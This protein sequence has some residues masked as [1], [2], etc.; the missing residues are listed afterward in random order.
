MPRK[1]SFIIPLLLLICSCSKNSGGS[2]NVDSSSSIAQEGATVKSIYESGYDGGY[3]MKK[4]EETGFMRPVSKKEGTPFSDKISSVKGQNQQFMKSFDKGEYD[5]R[6]WSG[7]EK[8][9]SI[10]P[11]RNNQKEFQYSPHFIKE[12]SDLATRTPKEKM[13]SFSRPKYSTDYAREQSSTRIE[14]KPNYLVNKRQDEFQ[15]PSIISNQNYQENQSGRSV[16][17]VKGLLSN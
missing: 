12:N 13:S 9:K 4:D 6:R 10:L 17:D 5:A 7:A 2:S 15:Q 1:I 14:K 16:D 8:K 3:E 11:W